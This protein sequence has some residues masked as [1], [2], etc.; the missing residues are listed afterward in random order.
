MFLIV[1]PHTKQEFQRCQKARF[2]I[3]ICRA[4]IFQPTLMHYFFMSTDC[5]HLLLFPRYKGVKCAQHT[6]F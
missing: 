6:K 4:Y 1:N 3:F 2:F 5:V